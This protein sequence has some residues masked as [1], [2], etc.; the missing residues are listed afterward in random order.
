MA[1]AGAPRFRASARIGAAFGV[2]EVVV[3]DWRS[4]FM[5]EGVEGFVSRDRPGRPPVKAQAA[6]LGFI[7]AMVKGCRKERETAS[8]DDAPKP[9]ELPYGLGASL[10]D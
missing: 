6:E 2:R 4:T 8:A 5:R 9:G 7:F 3:R 10:G 1:V